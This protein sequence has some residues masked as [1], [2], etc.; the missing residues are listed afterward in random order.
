MA[1]IEKDDIDGHSLREKVFNILEEDLLRGVYKPGESLIESKLSE[2]L[3]VS[4]TPIREAIRQLELEGLVR[5]IPNKGAVVL[6]ISSEDVDDIYTI[7]MM[8]EGLAVRWA[9]EKITDKDILKLKE[10]VDLEEFYTIKNDTP[11]LLK[12]DSNFHETIFKASKSRL[13]IKMLTMFH[14]YTLSARNTSF[15]SP[16]RAQ[17]TLNEHKAILKAIEEKDCDKAEILTVEHIKNAKVNLSKI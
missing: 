2:E 6:G 5:Y 4:R 14:H 8:I 11:R 16:G 15:E 7:R 12:V 1:R 9:T 17:E 13:L 3:G 10:I